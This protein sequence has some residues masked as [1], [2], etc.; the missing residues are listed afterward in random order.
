MPKT[1]VVFHGTFEIHG[2][3]RVLD[4]FFS[5]TKKRKATANMFPLSYLRDNGGI[6]HV[7]PGSH[8]AAKYTLVKEGIMK[9]SKDHQGGGRITVW[10]DNRAVHYDRTVL[11]D[12]VP[13]DVASDVEKAI[14]ERLKTE[15]YPTLNFESSV[16]FQQRKKKIME[17]IRAVPH[18]ERLERPS[19]GD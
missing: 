18:R 1:K 16:A 2:L 15:G 17:E 10:P 11:E 3:G 8:D 6:V 14:N 4:S 19:R 13:I 12:K 5:D 7:M 9:S